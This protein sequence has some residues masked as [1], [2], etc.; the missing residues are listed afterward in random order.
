MHYAVYRL[1]YEHSVLRIIVFLSLPQSLSRASMST[2]AY[3]WLIR[4]LSF[5]VS[6]TEERLGEGIFMCMFGF[7]GQY[8][9]AHF[10]FFYVFN[11]TC[12]GQ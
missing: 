3:Y 7:N 9:T 1:G 10:F 2:Q 5:P 11:K 4:L 8:V 6:A 12:R